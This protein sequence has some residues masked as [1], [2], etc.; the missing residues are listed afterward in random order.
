MRMVCAALICWLLL[1]TLASAQ[2]AEHQADQQTDMQSMPPMDE[3]ATSGMQMDESGAMSMHAK[4]FLQEIIHHGSSGTSAEPDS[5]PVPMLMTTKRNWALMFHANAFVIDEQQNGHRG[6]DKF[7]STN[8]FMGMAQHKAGQGTFT[9][10]MML[11]LEPATI[12]DRRYPLLFQQGET[13][14]GKPIAD[15]QHPHDFFMELA[16]LYDLKLANKALVS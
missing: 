13:A 9:A 15:G 8:W 7:F 4:N 12:S 2:H 5:T 16:A 11:S 3:D 1:P 14:F 6:Y 10:R